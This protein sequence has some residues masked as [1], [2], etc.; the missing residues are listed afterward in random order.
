[1]FNA[2]SGSRGNPLD[3]AT[4]KATIDRVVAGSP[5]HFSR[6]AVVTAPLFSDLPE[7]VRAMAEN[8][9]YDAHGRNA[10]GQ[11]LTGVTYDGKEILVQE[12]YLQRVGSRGNAV[13]RAHPSDHSW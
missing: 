9:G 12:N 7:A 5:S 11:E 10:S 6:D 8:E 3:L 2:K 1:M 13:A 4:L